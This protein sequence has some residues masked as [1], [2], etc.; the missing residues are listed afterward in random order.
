MRC[1]IVPNQMLRVHS[2]GGSTFPSDVIPAILKVWHQIEHLTPSVDAYLL[3]ELSC[4][5]LSQS[6]LKRW[7][8]RL[9]WRDFP[10]TKNNNKMSNDMRSVSDTKLTWR[11]K[12]FLW[13][14]KTTSF[15]QKTRHDMSS[16]GVSTYTVVVMLTQWNVETGLVM[17]KASAS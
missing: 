11:S 10:N 8:L 17:F 6:D 1:C 13:K 14:C 9:F 5:I 12:I 4:Q 3:E 2:P 15:W 16:T 7:S